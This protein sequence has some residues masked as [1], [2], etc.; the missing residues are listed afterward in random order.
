M[1][2]ITEQATFTPA[3]WVAMK[4]IGRDADKYRHLLEAGKGQKVDMLVRVQG[5][6]DCSP[7]GESEV[8]KKPSAEVVLAC[9]I[10]EANDAERSFIYS[11]M[12]RIKGKTVET[13]V[14]ATETALNML[15][16]LGDT[17]EE[18]YVTVAKN[19]LT[20]AGVV[21]RQPRKGATKGTFRVGRVDVD[22]I[23]TAVAAGVAEATRM[24]TLD[25]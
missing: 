18:G 6:V 14:T 20:N 15:P 23:S 7:D 11:V 10:K 17:V 9:L 4:V 21:V 3:E 1:G 25:E 2:V 22:R 19:L 5:E 24:I 13:A 16:G 12:D 8:I